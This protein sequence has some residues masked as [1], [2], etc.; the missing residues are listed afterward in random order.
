M[1]ARSLARMLVVV[2]IL[3]IALPA[4]AQIQRGAIYGT[5]VDNTGAV[6]PGV[7]VTLTSNVK[8]PQS[9]VSGS[10]GEFRF[11]ELDPGTYTLTASLQGFAPFKRENVIVNVGSNVEL[12]VQLALA[13]VQQQV[14][15]TAATPV[16]DERTH[17][18]TTTFGD[19]VLN[20]VPT[21]RDPWALLQQVPGVTVD[22]VNV[23]G[24]E[25]G[26]QSAMNA[27]GDL[28]GLNT[29]WNMDGVT[30]TDMGAVGSSPTYYDF[31]IFQE[32]QFTTGTVD[33]RQQTGALGINMV[34]KRGTNDFHGMARYFFDNH[35]LQT[36]N[37][38][39]GVQPCPPG[40]TASQQACYSGNHINQ[41]EDYG[42]NVGGPIV[43]NKLWFWG[44]AAKNDIKQFAITGAPD[45]TQLKDYAAKVDFQPTS[46]N[47]A[48]FMY[49]RGEKLKFG[50]NASTTRPPE[51]TWNQGGPTSIYKVEDSHTFG[52]HL[53]ATA[54]YAHVDGGFFLTPQGGMSSNVFYDLDTGI[55][56]GSY[57][58]Y[59]TQRPQDQVNGDVNYFRGKHELKAGFQYRR[60]PVSSQTTWAGN[61]AIAFVSPSDPTQDYAQL[62]RPANLTTNLRSYAWY[63]GDT[64]SLS[65]VTFEAAVR[66]DRQQTDNGATT[67]AANPIFPAGMPAL[68]Y[69]GSSNT[70]KWNN[71][72]PRVGATYRLNDKTIVRAAYSLFEAQLGAGNPSYP[73]ASNPLQ[74]A[75]VSYPFVDPGNHIPTA[76]NIDTSTVLSSYGF[77]PSNPTSLVSTSS[78][79]P[80]LKAP[81]TH[82]V[83]VALD[84]EL[85]PN[86]AISTSFGFGYTV[87]TVWALYPGLTQADF[88]PGLPLP[89]ANGITPNTQYYV[90]GPNVPASA[91][92]GSV[93]TNR[94]GYH[95]RYMSWDLTATK[96]L[97]NRWMF[98]GYLTLQNNQEFYDNPALSIQDPTPLSNAGSTNSEPNTQWA[99]VIATGNN[100]GILVTSAGGG[101]GSHGDVFMMSKWQYSLMGLY[102][103]GW[104]IQASGTVY[105]HQG[106]PNP[107]YIR[108]GRGPLGALSQ[109]LVNNDL[110]SVRNP[111]VSIT[112]LRAE[113]SFTVR[114]V[115]AI[116]SVDAFNVFNSNTVLQ[117]DRRIGNFSDSTGVLK[118]NVL[119]NQ[120]REIVAPRVFRLG[121]RLQF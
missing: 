72:S 6:L 99:P 94:P 31:D 58:D 87:D 10:Q 45:N 65:R 17:G 33:P 39:A 67:I 117:R 55:W 18:N 60:T 24:S 98:R 49:Y 5:V 27:R 52:S 3:A 113:K 76:A 121:F 36:T 78:I 90:L 12:P 38:P 20:E 107:M 69:P 81:R 75:G 47:H 9:I 14:T 86:F 19:A 108:V 35:N 64:I 91:V 16:L 32:V 115:S 118:D 22:R 7:T 51:T 57:L 109:V 103:F 82:S 40:V 92:N 25:S 8:A 80:N 111:N 105:G 34:T 28:S 61:G 74:A 11:G 120:P 1:N 119:F 13:G 93:V 44:S 104:G 26:Q 110:N 85:I 79:D 89:T 54:R 53:L 95:T 50:R 70:I 59:R 102:Q 97:A 30:I 48:D 84:R 46:A 106:Y 15:V 83:T 63:L 101:S 62:V 88:V 23:G 56:H 2:A 41:I 37:I 68:N 43:K 114:S 66:Y 4:S 100:G 112:D 96:R 21:A 116:L 42:A 73:V 71:W 77:D 29:M